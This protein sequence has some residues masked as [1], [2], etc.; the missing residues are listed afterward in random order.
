MNLLMIFRT[1]EKPNS[2]SQK[3]S[4]L[5]SRKS[6]SYIIM[7]CLVA[8][9]CFPENTYFSEML[10]FGKEKCFHVF[11]CISKNFP[12]NISL[13]LEKKKEN[14]NQK[15]QSHSP[16]KK[17]INDHNT[18]SRS[19]ARGSRSRSRSDRDPR[20]RWR[21]IAIDGARSRSGSRS[22]SRDRDGARSRSTGSSPLAMAPSMANDGIVMAPSDWS[23]SSRSR[24][25][26]SPLA[27]ARSLSLSFSGS[28]LK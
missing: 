3:H 20:S 12:K 10:I 23:W 24:T 11:G 21:Q 28:E 17:I 26:S 27:R 8:V 14:T 5:L 25:G 7:L 6:W 18:R 13:C 9:K 1:Q 22:R 15:T 2:K 4:H 16:G 19:T